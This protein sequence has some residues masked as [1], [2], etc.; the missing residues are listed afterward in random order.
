MTGWR[1][2]YAAGNSSVISAMNNLS[3]QSTSNPTSI[4]QK[5]A[6]E[7]F[8]GPQEPIK[9]MLKE[10][11]DRRDF[12]TSALNEINGVDCVLP[13]GAFYVFPD[14]SNF[15]GKEHNGKTITNSMEISAYLL[16]V[17]KVAVVPGVE[18]GSDNHV[19][20]SYATS[21]SDIQEG[22]KRIK[23]SLSKL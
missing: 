20:I 7:A 9:E 18:F 21:M 5:A 19:R 16:D 15:F 13:E 1:I 2:G 4:S 10:F 6:I 3:G 11:K 12:I 23:E 8:S 17:A 22:M 14:I